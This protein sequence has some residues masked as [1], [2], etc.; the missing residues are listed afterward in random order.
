MYG[1]PSPRSLYPARSS[2]QKSLGEIA[3][4]TRFLKDH[5]PQDLKVRLRWE[6][7]A[8]YLLYVLHQKATGTFKRFKDVPPGAHLYVGVT[9]SINGGYEAWGNEPR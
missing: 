1:E 7:A 9:S 2:S 3:Y 4:T 5:F 8:Q 6:G